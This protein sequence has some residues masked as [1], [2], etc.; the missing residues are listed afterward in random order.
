M[1]TRALTARGAGGVVSLRAGQIDWFEIEGRRFDS[2]NVL[3]CMDETGALADA[4]SLGNL[5]QAF[6]RPFDVIFDYQSARIAFP[7]DD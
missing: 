7:G 1:S 4:E 2:P 6:L 5:G 3:F